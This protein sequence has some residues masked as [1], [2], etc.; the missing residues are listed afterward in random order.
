MAATM[1]RMTE[2]DGDPIE[3]TKMEPNVD[4]QEKNN[5]FDF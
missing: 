4:L 5:H 3:I 2:K 1:K